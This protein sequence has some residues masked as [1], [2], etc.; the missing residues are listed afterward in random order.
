VATIN[1]RVFRG[2][3]SSLSIDLES[4]PSMQIK[5]QYL[6]YQDSSPKVMLSG[7]LPTANLVRR[8]ISLC[9]AELRVSE[10]VFPI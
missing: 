2:Y 5:L 8:L 1:E 3:Q 6:V 4:F 9:P 7:Y 10:F